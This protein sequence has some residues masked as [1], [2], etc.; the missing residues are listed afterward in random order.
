MDFLSSELISFTNI[1]MLNPVFI[2]LPRFVFVHTIS[3]DP[4]S[5]LN[6]VF[7]LHS[8]SFSKIDE[9]VIKLLYVLLIVKEKHRILQRQIELNCMADFRPVRVNSMT[10]G[11]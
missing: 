6:Y 7:F 3:I 4:L 1:Y 9:Y 10:K 2:Y 8:F 11:A 5:T